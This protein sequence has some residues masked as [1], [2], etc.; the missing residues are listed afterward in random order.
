MSSTFHHNYKQKATD[1]E[2]DFWTE[3]TDST[4]GTYYHGDVIISDFNSWINDGMKD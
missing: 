2:K 1:K 4:Y 3:K